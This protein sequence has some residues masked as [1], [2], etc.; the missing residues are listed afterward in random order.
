MQNAPSVHVTALQHPFQLQQVPVVL[1]PLSAFDLL[2][3]VN[4]I[5]MPMIGG[6][7][8]W[9]GPVIGALLL[10]TIQQIVTVTISSEL[11]ILIVGVV[12][13][14]FVALAPRGIVG[15]FQDFARKRREGG[16]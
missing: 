7:A 1:Y 6:T 16:K 12:L 8:V 13:I 4:A 14:G 11:N 9:F 5:A 10:G 15:L 3:A 2:I